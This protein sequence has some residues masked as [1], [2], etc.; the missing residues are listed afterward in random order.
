MRRTEAAGVQ[1]LQEDRRH[2][3]RTRAQQREAQRGDAAAGDHEP[4]A[5]RAALDRA[6]GEREQDDLRKN[7][8]R[9]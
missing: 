4:Q 5:R 6:T 3:A 9:P 7:A 8:D 1:H 2:Q